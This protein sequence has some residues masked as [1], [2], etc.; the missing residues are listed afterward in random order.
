[1]T[2]ER[3][4]SA[5]NRLF[6]E[7]RASSD[8][9]LLT[10]GGV[11]MWPVLR[12]TAFHLHEAIIEKVQAPLRA[13][14]PR[15]PSETYAVCD[16]AETLALVA[17]RLNGAALIGRSQASPVGVLAFQSD[18]EVASPAQSREADSFSVGLQ[19]AAASGGLSF[20]CLTSFAPRLAPQLTHAEW[21]YAA[22]PGPRIAQLAEMSSWLRSVTDIC[23][24]F[25]SAMGSQLLHASH[26]T[27]NALRLL[28]LV[29]PS[30]TLLDRFSPRLLFTNGA[31]GIEKMAMITAA[32]KRG[33]L[34]VDHQHGMY[35]SGSETFLSPLGA[36][37]GGI[38]P[39][40]GS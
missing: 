5:F 10:L 23:A 11:N 34:C 35:G 40:P 7:I 12:L 4:I 16:G 24:T 32:R 14:L 2:A 33:I 29:A 39:T 26:V 20:A 1:M 8:L 36:H 15:N 22:C 13:A 25:N 19:R 6:R 30:E 17:E 37:S 27:A 3:T 28:S 9:T 38:D 31:F 21:L 18:R